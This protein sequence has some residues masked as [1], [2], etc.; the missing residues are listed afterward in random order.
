MEIRG[1]PTAARI[2]KRARV[3]EDRRRLWELAERLTGV[4]YL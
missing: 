4:S 2:A 1:A 3:E